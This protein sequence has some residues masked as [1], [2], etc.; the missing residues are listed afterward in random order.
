M[1]LGAPP[2][3]HVAISRSGVMSSMIQNARPIVEM[4]RSSSCTLMSVTAA[5]GR[6]SC[7]DCQCLP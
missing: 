2:R 1:P 5:C 7:S 3:I 4:T 6:S